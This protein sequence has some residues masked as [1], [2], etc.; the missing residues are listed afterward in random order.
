MRSSALAASATTGTTT[1]DGEAGDSRS[2]AQFS[3][4]DTVF[5]VVF[6]QR[7]TAEYM[8]CAMAQISVQSVRW[9][10]TRF[11]GR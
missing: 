4:F 8:S 7:S 2:S 9:P 6:Q 5:D 11:S 10:A 3:A 1:T